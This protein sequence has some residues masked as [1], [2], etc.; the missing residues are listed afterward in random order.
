M[1]KL[2]F[3]RMTPR[4]KRL[5]SFTLIELLMAMAIIAI[6]ASLVLGAGGML[7][8]KAKRSRASSEIAAMSAALEGYKTDNGIYPVGNTTP[9][10]GSILTGPPAPGVYPADP[11]PANGSYQVSSEALF[12]AL[13]GITNY[14]SDTPV[15][16]VKS[17]M[18]FK[19]SQIGNPAGPSYIQ[20]PWTYSYGYSTGKPSNPP[21]PGDPAPNNGVGFFDLWSTGGTK[22]LN[23]TDPNTWV[24]NWQ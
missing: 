1:P 24:S 4:K 19:T 3:W 9:S 8:T 17:Y 2:N 5:A 20:D 22:G 21:A 7:F 13:S 16:G 18:T 11:T 15:A 23:A 12:Q 6:L 10:A 14:A